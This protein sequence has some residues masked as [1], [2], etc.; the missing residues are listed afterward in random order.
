MTEQDISSNTSLSANLK[1]IRA[2]YDTEALSRQ[3]MDTAAIIRYYNETDAAYGFFHS[4]QGS[5]H[6]ALTYDGHFDQDG[7]YEQ[8]RIVERQIERLRQ[9]GY[10]VRDVLELGC[11]K[12]FN[13]VYLA[14]HHPNLNFTA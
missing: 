3:R 11:G 8:A 6:L 13:T 4:R 9:S 14:S 5:I 12:G 2:V 10:M 7:F 1:L